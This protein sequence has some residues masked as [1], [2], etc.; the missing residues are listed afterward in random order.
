MMTHYANLREAHD[1]AILRETMRRWRFYDNL[2][3]D[4]DAVS[5][6]ANRRFPR[7]R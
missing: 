3:A 7:A 4:R 6:A 5:T 2:R 1:L